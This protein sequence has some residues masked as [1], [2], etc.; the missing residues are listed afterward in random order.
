[1]FDNED[2]HQSQVDEIY[3]TYFSYIFLLIFEIEMFSRSS[4]HSAK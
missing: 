1:M 2:T 3:M 4:S